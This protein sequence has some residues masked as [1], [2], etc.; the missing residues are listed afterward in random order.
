[1]KASEKLTVNPRLDKDTGLPLEI[2]RDELLKG[3]DSPVVEKDILDIMSDVKNKGREYIK[4][5][6]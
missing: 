4:T 6:A 5:S 2:L 3:T 1:M